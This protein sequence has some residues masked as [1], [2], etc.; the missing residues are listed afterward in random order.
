MREIAEKVASRLRKSVHKHPSMCSRSSSSLGGGLTVCGFT[1]TKIS[2]RLTG[3]LRCLVAEFP[4]PQK[5]NLC[6]TIGLYIPQ[7]VKGYLPS[8]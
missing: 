1:Q 7:K 3:S 5:A 8:Y 4:G 2:A 6:I